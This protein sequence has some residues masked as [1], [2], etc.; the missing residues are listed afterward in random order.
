MQAKKALILVNVLLV[1]FLVW[2]LFFTRN[3]NTVR[4]RVRL[5][6]NHRNNYASVLLEVFTTKMIIIS[7]NFA[8]LL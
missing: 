4:L 3:A 1:C 5:I 2:Y 6:W 8:S 7:I